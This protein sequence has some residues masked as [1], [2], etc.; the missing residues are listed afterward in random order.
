MNEDE[1]RQLLSLL[2]A[3]SGIPVPEE[4]DAASLM[5][6]YLDAAPLPAAVENALAA[7]FDAAAA[8]SQSASS[9]LE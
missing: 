3:E 9:K 6:R 4:A 1:A 5:R 2:L 8:P 7:I